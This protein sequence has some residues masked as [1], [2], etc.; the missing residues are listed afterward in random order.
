MKTLLRLCTCIA[1]LLMLGQPGHAVTVQESARDIPVIADVDI[2]V[3]GG[4]SG[5]VAAAVEAARQG[6]SVFLAAPRPYLGEDMC[7]SL[8]LWLEPGEEPVS[9]L[10]QSLYVPPQ[11]AITIGRG[12]PFSYSSDMPA[13]EQHADSDP[14]A[15]L[16][17]GKVGGAAT[18]SVQYDGNATLT[19]D[20]GAETA[21]G[22]VHLLVYQR[23]ADFALARCAISGS[24][25]GQNWTPLATAVNENLTQGSQED[26]PGLVS[27]DLAG[28]ARYLKLA[29]ERAPDT[30]RLL[31]GEIVVEPAD[32]PTPG[33]AGRIPPMP[34]QVKRMLDEALVSAGVQFLY[35]CYPTDLLRDEK[36]LPAGIVMANRAGRQAVLAKVIIDATPRA[37]VAHMAGAEFTGGADTQQFQR[38]VIGG[39]P[40]DA[41]GLQID[42]MP[43]PVQLV[44]GGWDTQACKPAFRCT[45]ALPL[46]A[47]TFAA[48]A[49]A[50]QQAR[51]LTWSP[52]QVLASETLFEIPA[53]AVRGKSAA[54]GPWPGA[55]SIDLDVFRPAGVDR[56]YLLGPC[57]G[58]SREAAE[59]FARPLNLMAVGERIGV[60]A[61]M[62]AKVAARAGAARATGAPAENPAPGDVKE[63][64]AGPR[65]TALDQTATVRSEAKAVPILG[66]YDVVVVGGGTGGAPAGVGAARRGAKTLV[67][68]YLPGLGGVGTLGLIGTYYYG[69]K[70]GFT[71]E[72]DHGVAAM[73]TTPMPVTTSWN[74]EWKMEWYR[75]E[76]RKAGADIWYGALGC[77]AFVENGRV[78]GVVVATPEGRGIVLAETVIDATGNADI[79]CA[80]GAECMTTGANHVAVQ[81]TGLP[82]Y[83]PGAHYTNTDYTQT[84][85]GDMLDEWRTL[86]AGRVKYAD[87]YD[88]GQIIDSRE[89]RRIVGDYVVSPLDIWNQRTYPDTIGVSYSNFDTHGYTVHALF[90]LK[91][92]DEE[93]VRAF[94][95]YRALLPK[96]IDG[97]LVTGL[98]ISAHRDAMPILRMQPD[99]QNQGYAAGVAAAMAAAE[100]IVP[101]DVNV[102]ALQQHLVEIGNVPASVL[103]DEG[104]V[105]FT[106]DQV[107]AAVLSLPDNYQGLGVVLAQANEALPMLRDAYANAATPEA[108]YLYAHVLGMLRDTTA[109]QTL[110]ESVATCAWDTGWSFSG[111]G[112]FG[113]S[114]SPVD[115]YII[116]LG[117][118]R[119]RSGLDFILNKA[120]ALDSKSE[121]SHHRAIAIALE[122]IGAPEAA[123]VLAELL[124]KPDMAGY[125]CT[126]V[127][128]ARERAEFAN[129][130][131]DRDRSIRELTLARALFRCGDQDGIGEKTLRAYAAD[132]RGHLARHAQAVLAEKA[133]PK[134]DVPDYE[135]LDIEGLVPGVPN[136]AP[137]K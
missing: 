39:R 105:P 48:L 122:N 62:E 135:S 76:L 136:V 67:I 64:L 104:S 47:P 117:R 38:I 56:L 45:L 74:V 24:T 65:G 73:G 22:R 99:I 41:P 94:T 63:T 85:D 12:L 110:C 82:P 55:K 9:P 70:E 120:R 52:D 103:S 18:E 8:R 16:T 127:E 101:R 111:M 118:T 107:R 130:N 13:A 129:P 25:D 29:L 78:R 57:A 26:T 108:K 20:L 21:L 61:A 98:G 68:E 36:G 27:A 15:K 11:P 30:K 50:E 46:P 92:P 128:Q 34:M 1:G 33:A 93:G 84:L 17:D 72:V 89:R 96:E 102:K 80:A 23:R 42:A 58:M 35:G 124:A 19:L 53:E 66:Q 123:P 88:L 121:F 2:V 132:L 10:A 14:P 6:A 71:G 97:I 106:P 91:A 83:K 59:R 31:L 131:L 69:F 5:A 54:T 4:S 86:L 126:T 112:Q 114:L 95:P 113:M 77:G 44:Q 40:A 60:A 43:A 51:D 32:T 75:R 119:D 137:E 100:D 49:A 79:A 28:S 90:A 81:G 134:T 116:A 115:S 7:A 87:S 125:A 109:V 37:A 133:A 3:V